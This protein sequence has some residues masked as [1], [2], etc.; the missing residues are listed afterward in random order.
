MSSDE[1]SAGVVL[2]NA[3]DARSDASETHARKQFGMDLIKKRPEELMR[4][5]ALSAA[6]YKPKE[7]YEYNGKEISVNV[8]PIYYPWDYPYDPPGKLRA[9][10][11]QVVYSLDNYDAGTKSG[12]IE[13]AF[14]GT[15][16]GDNLRTDGYTLKFSLG[17]MGYP[18]AGGCCWSERFVR[19]GPQYCC[20]A[21]CKDMCLGYSGLQPNDITGF[22]D[23]NASAMCKHGGYNGVMA[24]VHQGFHTAAVSTVPSVEHFLNSELGT[25]DKNEC[26]YNCIQNLSK[27]L[28]T[29]FDLMAWQ[30]TC[31]Y[32]FCLVPC[33]SE[34]RVL[35]QWLPALLCWPCTST[36]SQV[37]DEIAKKLTIRLTG[38]SLGGAMATLCALKLKLK[39][40]ENVELVTFGSPRV[41]NHHFSRLMKKVLP[42]TTARF[43]NMGDPVA[44][45]PPKAAYYAHTGKK[46]ALGET[47]AEQAIGTAE[48]NENMEYRY[49]C[50]GLIKTKVPKGKRG[51]AMA[52]YRENIEKAIAGAASHC[53]YEEES[54][55]SHSYGAGSTS[56]SEVLLPRT[57]SRKSPRF[58]DDGQVEM[59]SS[60]GHP[61]R[62]TTSTEVSFALSASNAA[63]PLPSGKLRGSLRGTMNTEASYALSDGSDDEE[64]KGV[65]DAEVMER[66]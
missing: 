66:S 23:F 54:E 4:C 55:S 32:C 52:A 34:A 16:N 35:C 58:E 28:S 13:I 37:P 5:V 24:S 42:E 38:H 10:P 17:A 43:V 50:C 46:I 31:L 51:H 49:K 30:Y 15:C 47:L 20:C 19:F 44:K 7:Q 11:Y 48:E 6:A 1:A 14:R 60:F 41:G 27:Y 3:K 9:E 8:L 61:A 12:V 2:V 25:K 62:D 26:G 65:M 64:A 21:Y 59:A 56:L 36:E 63:T 57:G 45:F 53:A 29:T 33:C 22:T 39:G 18:V 40:Y